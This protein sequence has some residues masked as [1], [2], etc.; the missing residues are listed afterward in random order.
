MSRWDAVLPS[1]PPPL[2]DGNLLDSIDAV[3][4]QMAAAGVTTSFTIEVHYAGG[5]YR[6]ARLRPPHIDF[7]SA[8][9]KKTA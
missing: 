3:H 2:R 7:E 1:L 4:A 6:L 5:V 8:T 9:D